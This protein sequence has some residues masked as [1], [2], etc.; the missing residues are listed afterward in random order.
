MSSKSR[1]TSM[2]R[3]KTGSNSKLANPSLVQSSTDLAVLSCKL[4]A[5]HA[6][7]QLLRYDHCCKQWRQTWGMAEHAYDSFDSSASWGSCTW[8]LI[9]V[10]WWLFFSASV[11]AWQK[12]FGACVWLFVACMATCT[13]LHFPGLVDFAVPPLAQLRTI[14]SRQLVVSIACPNLLLCPWVLFSFY[15][16]HFTFV[17]LKDDLTSSLAQFLDRHQ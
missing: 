6:S 3:K 17:F 10:C 5:M 2:L 13:W 9:I 12:R 1:F 11:A 7:A 16:P 14:L 15:I 8:N 4:F